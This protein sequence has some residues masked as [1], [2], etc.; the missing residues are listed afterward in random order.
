MSIPFWVERLE[1][2]GLLVSWCVPTCLELLYHLQI[3]I[4]KDQISILLA[5]NQWLL[6][7]SK[8]FLHLSKILICSY[9]YFLLSL[10]GIHTILFAILACFQFPSLTPYKGQGTVH[11]VLLIRRNT[12]KD[13]CFLHFFSR[14]TQIIS[15]QLASVFL[16]FFVNLTC[17]SATLNCRNWGKYSL[18]S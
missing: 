9:F 14:Q 7:L 4:N 10:S 12:W 2:K 8:N 5:T 3:L 18:I 17:R 13:N 15:L 16:V 1:S 11:S 6:V